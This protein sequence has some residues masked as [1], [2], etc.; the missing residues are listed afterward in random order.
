VF[1]L[2]PAPIRSRK[3]QQQEHDGRITDR[4]IN[5]PTLTG[6][7]AKRAGG[8]DVRSPNNNKKTFV[9]KLDS[10][11]RKFDTIKIAWLKIQG[12][13]SR[14]ERFKLKGEDGSRTYRV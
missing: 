6:N 4:Q 11:R 10:K 12:G 2:H 1:T 5:S 3:S 13:I 7:S 8:G 14:H 9:F